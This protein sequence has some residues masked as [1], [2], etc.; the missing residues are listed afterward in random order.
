MSNKEQFVKSLAD[1]ML[2]Y[3]LGR[4]LS[5]TDKCATEAVAK[6]AASDGYRFNS[7]VTAVVLSDP[8]R[9]RKGEATKTK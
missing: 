5:L 4:G 8:F 2:T 9:K 6:A 1:K 7:L 3:G